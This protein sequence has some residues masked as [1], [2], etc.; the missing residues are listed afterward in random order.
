M[1][2][3]LSLGSSFISAKVVR[4]VKL[5]KFICDVLIFFFNH[6]Y[7]LFSACWNQALRQMFY[8]HAFSFSI[9]T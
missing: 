4:I 2:S 1:M 3:Q 9:L 7:H 8:L 6:Y 5:V